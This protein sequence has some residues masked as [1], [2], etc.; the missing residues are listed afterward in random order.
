MII[1]GKNV[2]AE[3]LEKKEI[4]RQIYLSNNFNDEKIKRIIEKNNYK[5][6]YLDKEQIDR[7]VN[8]NSQGI[9][10]EIKDYE[11][12]DFETI[13]SDNKANFIV[14]LDHIED[15]HNIGAIIRTSECANVDYIIIPNKRV[16]SIN[17]TVMKTSSGALIN[18][19][20]CEVA[21]LRNT[22]ERLKKLGFWIVGT[23]MDGEDYTKIDYKGKVAIVIGNE[24]SGLSRIVKES[25]DFIATIPM[26]GKINSLNASV[27]C[28]IMIYE[29]L[30]SREE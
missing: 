5:V 1:Y 20:I 13:E 7:K 17:A 28:G 23:D 26:K 30:K 11:F 16:V 3:V 4:V 24:G 25:C 10:I 6:I 15:P 27:A 22:I 12:T 21:N 9:L 18:S 29:I 8:A 19:R 14:I 2:A